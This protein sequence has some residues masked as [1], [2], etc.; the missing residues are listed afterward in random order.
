V[1]VPQLQLRECQFN[2]VL[3][4]NMNIQENYIE[5]LYYQVHT[6]QCDEQI[7]FLPYFMSIQVYVD[8][9]FFMSVTGNLDADL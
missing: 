5:A 9:E 1:I 3:L 6:Q 2:K 4:D 8:N 7:K